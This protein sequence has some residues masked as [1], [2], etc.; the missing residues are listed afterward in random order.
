[1][2]GSGCK[3]P[4]TETQIRQFLDEKTFGAYDKLKTTKELEEVLLN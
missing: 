1:M 4:F 3:A 2:D